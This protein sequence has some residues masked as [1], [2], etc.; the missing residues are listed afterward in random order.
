MSFQSS[1]LGAEIDISGRSYCTELTAIEETKSY[2]E[3]KAKD[4]DMRFIQHHIFAIT[5]PQVCLPSNHN[6]VIAYI[7]ISAVRFSCKIQLHF[8][9][10]S[11]MTLVVKNCRKPSFQLF[12]KIIL[13]VPMRCP[14]MWLRV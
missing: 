5:I 13:M 2:K 7:F 9:S 4:E 8:G 10:F 14:G 12:F 1:I 6:V 11:C 3:R